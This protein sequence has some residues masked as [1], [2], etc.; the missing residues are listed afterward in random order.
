M[1][2]IETIKT[3]IENLPM[4]QHLSFQLKDTSIVPPGVREQYFNG[5]TQVRFDGKRHPDGSTLFSVYL[6]TY[7]VVIKLTDVIP[8]TF[9]VH[10]RTVLMAVELLGDF[11]D[12]ELSR[13][14]AAIGKVLSVASKDNL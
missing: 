1:S 4:G 11:S 13:K 12:E 3:I 6:P 2:D 5:Q 7:P 8:E 14:M 10:G 9:K